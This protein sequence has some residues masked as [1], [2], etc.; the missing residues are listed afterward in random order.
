M[1]HTDSYSQLNRT[2]VKRDPTKRQ[3]GPQASKNLERRSSTQH[4]I[5]HHLEVER[6]QQVDNHS[7][8]TANAGGAAA[9]R[10][11]DLFEAVPLHLL[12]MLSQYFYKCDYCEGRTYCIVC[13]VKFHQ[14]HKDIKPACVA[15]CRE[16]FSGDSE[17]K[18]AYCHTAHI[19][20][21]L[22][23][24]QYQSPEMRQLK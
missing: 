6:L 12:Q 14:D 15:S 7:V 22:N 3:S 18:G 21:Y 13:A 1:P 23:S 20:R 16:M 17:L 8:Y 4:E 9:R 19:Q 2:N 11:R 24:E 5:A 10:E